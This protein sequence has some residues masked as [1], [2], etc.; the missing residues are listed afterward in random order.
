MLAETEPKKKAE[1]AT[2]LKI[3]CN[4]F[5]SSPCILTDYTLRE[6]ADKN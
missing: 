2:R 3:F 5:I 6:E 1:K 4:V